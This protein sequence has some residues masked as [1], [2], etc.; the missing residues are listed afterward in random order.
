M[1][2]IQMPR[3]TVTTHIS[4]LVSAVLRHPNDC[5]YKCLCAC[6]EMK[7]IFN[8]IYVFSYYYSS[9]SLDIT[10]LLFFIFSVLKWYPKQSTFLDYLPKILLMELSLW[11]TNNC[12]NSDFTTDVKRGKTYFWLG[13]AKQT[14][15]E[16]ADMCSAV[17]CLIPGRKAK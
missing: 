7:N 16:G 8:S 17:K 5:I 15:Y 14:K 3:H 10:P 1:N 11:Y 13:K 9:K 6:I 2:E 4:S 12:W